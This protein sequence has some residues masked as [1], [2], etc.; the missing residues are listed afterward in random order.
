MLLRRF[1]WAFAVCVLALSGAAG[2]D[3]KDTRTVWKYATGS[4]EKQADGTWVHKDGNNTTTYKEVTNKDDYIE[5][6]DRDRKVSIVLNGK[7]AAI[8]APGAK[9]RY[10]DGGWAGA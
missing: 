5:I 2:A 7:Y 9:V 3:E 6:F 4:Y 1:T 8:R 10:L